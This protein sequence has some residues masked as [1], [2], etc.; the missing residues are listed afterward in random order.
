MPPDVFAFLL[1][2]VSVFWPSHVFI[3]LLPDFF[4]SMPP[5]VFVFSL[6]DVFIYMLFVYSSLFNINCFHG[7]VVFLYK[8][9]LCLVI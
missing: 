7:P 3:F 6:P 9:L 4:V 5:V 2:N 1:P 8:Q